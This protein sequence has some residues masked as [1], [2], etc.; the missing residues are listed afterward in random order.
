MGQVAEMKR[1]RLNSLD[2]DDRWMIGHNEL[3]AL[4][5]KFENREITLQTLEARR[6]TIVDFISGNSN[7]VNSDGVIVEF[8][9]GPSDG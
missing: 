6:K 2:K 5:K 8:Y 4:R 1:C 9:V 3:R 7:R